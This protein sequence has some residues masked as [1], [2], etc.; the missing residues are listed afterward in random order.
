MLSGAVVFRLA[1]AQQVHE[2]RRRPSDR[3]AV[4]PPGARSGSASATPADAVPAR[5]RARLCR[6]RSIWIG[7]ASKSRPAIGSSLPSASTKPQSTSALSVSAAIAG[8]PSAARRMPGSRMRV[9]RDHLARGQ[10]IV[11]HET[12]DAVL[13]AVARVTHARADHRLQIE[14]QAFLGAAGDVVQVEAHGPQEFPGAT[15]VRALR[16]ASAR[17]RHRRVRPWSACRRRSARSSRAFA[18]R[19]GRRGLP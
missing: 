16:V 11:A 14:G 13:L 19:A 3:R 4:R 2:E 5:D 10:E 12:F 6:M 15:A 8:G 17:R 1:A 7:S 9:S 18:D